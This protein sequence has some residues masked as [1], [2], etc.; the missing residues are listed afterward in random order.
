MTAYLLL[1]CRAVIAVVFA[2][3]A[4]AK[5]RARRD[6]ASALRVMAVLPPRLTGLAVV[7]VPAAEAALALL[8]WAPGP[9]A[10]WAF[11]ASGGLIALFTAVLVRLL[12]RGADVS[13]SCFGASGVPV[14]KAHVGRNLVLMAVVGAGLAASAAPDP[15]GLGA[16]GAAVALLAAAFASALIIAT[17][18]LVELFTAAR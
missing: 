9:I 16:A 6:F 18:T 3:S 10:T 11:F 5:L 8:A 14:S 2:T 13:C 12:R 1:G 4:L 7:G 15:G 17:D